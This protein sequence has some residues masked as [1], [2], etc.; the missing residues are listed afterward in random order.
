[1]IERVIGKNEKFEIIF[2][3]KE[4]DRWEAVLPPDLSG[5]YYIDLYAY[6][7]AG[8]VGYMSKA[9]F[10]VDINNLCIHLLKTD[11]YISV[12][13]AHEYEID[14]DYGRYHNVFSFDMD[15]IEYIK[16]MNDF[17]CDIKEVQKCNV[18]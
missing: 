5:E 15:L 10:T 14:I 3:L 2:E 8:N 7:K 18:V 1:M 4:N 12:R 11:Y 16:F 9:L 13:Y 17:E 6:D